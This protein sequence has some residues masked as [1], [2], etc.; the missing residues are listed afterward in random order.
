MQTDQTSDAPYIS[1]D[2]ESLLRGSPHY[3]NEPVYEPNDV[4]PDEPNVISPDAT[5][6]QP[7][8]TIDV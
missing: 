2:D 8:A 3:A 1:T 7:P 6:T 5:K 4:P